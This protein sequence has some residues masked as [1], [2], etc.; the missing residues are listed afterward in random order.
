MFAC[1]HVCVPPHF[2]TH[3]L[4]IDCDASNDH[5]ARDC[6]DGN[7]WDGTPVTGGFCPTK[8]Y[9]RNRLSEPIQ[10]TLEDIVVSG[11]TL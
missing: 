8:C 9:N 1:N 4:C 5:P 2:W 6:H 10:R 7:D 11:W 3:A